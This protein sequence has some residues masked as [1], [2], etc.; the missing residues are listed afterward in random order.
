MAGSQQENRGPPVRGKEKQKDSSH[1]EGGLVWAGNVSP[2][3]F[4]LVV[5]SS[6]LPEMARDELCGSIEHVGFQGVSSARR[7]L[8]KQPQ[9]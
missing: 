3:H 2:M 5:Y 8:L 7:G 1:L 4:G 6:Y 9:N